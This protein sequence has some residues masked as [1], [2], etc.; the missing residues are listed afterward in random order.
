MFSVSKKTYSR[1][2]KQGVW[3]SNE[4]WVVSSWHQT[5]NLHDWVRC[6]DAH[7]KEQYLYHYNKTHVFI[8]FVSPQL[9]ANAFEI[10]PNWKFELTQISKYLISGGNYIERGERW[11]SKF[12]KKTLQRTDEGR[13]NSLIVPSNPEFPNLSVLAA[14]SGGRRERSDGFVGEGWTHVRMHAH[15]QTP[16]AHTIG[17]LCTHTNMHTGHPLTLSGDQ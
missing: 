14:W 4:I 13:G 9:V 3:A 10:I 1:C 17:A 2:S 12:L 11:C 7:M 16:V 6:R 5:H 8:I 15:A